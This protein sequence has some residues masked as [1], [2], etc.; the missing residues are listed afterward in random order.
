MKNICEI[1][2]SDSN[3][4]NRIFSISDEIQ[5]DQPIIAFIKESIALKEERY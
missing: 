2:G 5:S 3:E 4:L 1:V